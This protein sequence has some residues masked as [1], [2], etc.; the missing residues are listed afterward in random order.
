MR[1]LPFREAML[2]MAG[3]VALNIPLGFVFSQP[4]EEPESDETM[5]SSIVLNAKV[6]CEYSRAISTAH[7][8]YLTSTITYY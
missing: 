6:R 5:V 2:A 1:A 3:L 4:Q 7:L 8:Y